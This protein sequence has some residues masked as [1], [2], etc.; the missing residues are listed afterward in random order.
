MDGNA[1]NFSEIKDE[2]RKLKE[3]LSEGLDHANYLLSEVK[4]LL[5][6]LKDEMQ[7]LKQNMSVVSVR[8][9]LLIKLRENVR[10]MK[11]YNKSETTV[12]DAKAE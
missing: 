7:R 2:I 10:F 12:K 8:G 1:S 9:E 11:R 4:E 5:W 6:E 3:T